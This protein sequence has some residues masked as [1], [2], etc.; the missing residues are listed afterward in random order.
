MWANKAKEKGSSSSSLMFGSVEHHIV[1]EE[2]DQV[3]LELL[4]VFQ[5]SRVVM[6]H[7]LYFFGVFAATVYVKVN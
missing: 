3:G 6:S 7:L 2:L 5:G 1:N 4:K